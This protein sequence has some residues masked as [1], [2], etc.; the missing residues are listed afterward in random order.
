MF[1]DD[2]PSDGWFFS[3]KGVDTTLG[4][5]SE[6]WELD[7]FREVKYLQ[8]YSKTLSMGMQNLQALQISGWT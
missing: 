6:I 7:S 8:G 2:Y 5:G 4:D 3:I 1:T